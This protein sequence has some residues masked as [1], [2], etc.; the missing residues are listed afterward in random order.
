MVATSMVMSYMKDYPMV[1]GTQELKFERNP[2]NGFGD[3]CD[4]DDERTTEKMFNFI[5]SADI[6]K[7]N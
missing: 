1:Q 3:I 2:L 5:S 7:Q 4:S 6:V